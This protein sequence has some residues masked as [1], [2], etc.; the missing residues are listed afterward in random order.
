[1]TNR[2]KNSENNG[3]IKARWV[4]RVFLLAFVLSVFFSFISETLMDRFNIF[5]SIFVLLVIIAIGIIFDIIGIAVTSAS[6][7]PFHAMAADKVPGGK[8]A[9]KLIRNADIVSNFCNDVVGDICGILSGAAGAAIVLKALALAKHI[10]ETALSIL[11]AGIIST[12]TIGG[13]A[14]GKGI[15]INN[16]KKVVHN[17]ALVIFTIKQR[18][19]IDILASIS[20]KRDTSKR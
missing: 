18:L 20:G 7:T 15:A 6:E 1:M 11:M 2:S 5:I 14:I 19:G 17:V 12:L 4:Y 8:E 13:K 9:V 3:S 16:S 10:N